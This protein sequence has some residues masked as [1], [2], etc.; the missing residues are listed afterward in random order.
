MIYINYIKIFYR[1]M[2][3]IYAASTRRREY[4]KINVWTFKKM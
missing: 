4:Y 3:S 1:I 2:D